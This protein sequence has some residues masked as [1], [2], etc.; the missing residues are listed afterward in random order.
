MPIAAGPGPTGKGQYDKEV[1]DCNEAIRLN[2]KCVDAYCNRAWAYGAKGQYDKAVA[3][4][5]EVIRINPKNVDS[6]YGRDYVYAQNL[7]LQRQSRT[8]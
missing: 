5:T 8:N 3:D 1:A 6:Y 2:P 7:E 4:C